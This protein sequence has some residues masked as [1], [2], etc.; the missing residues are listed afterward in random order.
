VRVVVTH[1]GLAA[2]ERRHQASVLIDRFC[3]MDADPLVFLGDINEWFPISRRLRALRR[4][5]GK[6]PALSSYPSLLPFLALDRIW[7][8]PSEALI[9]VRV[10]RTALSRIA[11]DHLP[12]VAVVGNQLSLERPVIGDQ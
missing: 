7:V 9:H 8:R 2:A 4:C 10:H 5:L 1:L 11:S 6:S 12:V 3:R